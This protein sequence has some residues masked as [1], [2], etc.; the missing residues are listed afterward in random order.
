MVKGNNTREFWRY[1]TD[2][3][4]WAQLET[5]PSGPS[6][7]KIKGGNDLAY[8]PPAYG[9]SGF[10]YLLKG[11]KTEFYR[12]NIATG[13]WEARDN[14][15]W[16]VKDRYTEGSFLVFDG[17]RTIYCHQANYYAKDSVPYRHAMFRYDVAGDTWY[18]GK[19]R[20]M[21]LAGMAGGRIRNKKSKDGGC[22]T[23]YNGGLYAL[24]GGN[25]QM[26][27]KY[28]PGTGAWQELDT[29]LSWGT[30]G[31]KRRVKAGADM[32]SVDNAFYALK[33][34][35][36]RELWRYAVPPLEATSHKPQAGAMAGNTDVR[37]STFDVFP[38]P[39]AA[40]FAILR[41][42]GFQGPRVQGAN[43]RVFDA[44][45]RMV[46]ARSFVI[47]TSSFALPLDLR[48][49]PA[50]VYLVRLDAEGMTQTQKLVVNR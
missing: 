4:R 46:L 39:I 13:H 33:G 8:V 40:G 25:T 7:K 36:T 11:Y 19:L 34:N 16:A 37:R 9:D 48:K 32:V 41:V 43:V 17:N 1:D 3:W 21:P 6:K 50:G 35:K 44:L 18:S 26:F 24:K 30:T 15:R 29:I 31:K 2:G 14:A 5:I 27:Y 22:G 12:Y 28:D 38:N 23:W 45:G 47:R 20:G 49:V 42:R 10:I